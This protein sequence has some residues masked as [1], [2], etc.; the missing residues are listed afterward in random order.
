MFL[1]PKSVTLTLEAFEI[2]LKEAR[3][4]WNKQEFVLALGEYQSLLAECEK[5]NMYDHAHEVE[6][7]KAERQALTLFKIRDPLQ[8]TLFDQNE[9]DKILQ[10]AKVNREAATH[11]R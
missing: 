8:S 10:K 1:N 6:R 9:N 4:Y 2:Q 7:N 11:C 3:D 5:A